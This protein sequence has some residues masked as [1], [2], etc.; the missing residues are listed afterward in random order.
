M[1]K[2][3]KEIIERL[4]GQNI[5]FAENLPDIEKQFA[6]CIN[7]GY[8]QFNE[9]LLYL[10]Y[11]RISKVFFQF[12][13]DGTLDYRSSST[14]SDFDKF[15]AH[16]EKII[17]YF[18]IL[19]GNVKFGYKQF[20]SESN[21]DEF[22][23]WYENLTPLHES[24]FKERHSPLFNLTI[25]DDDNTYYLGYLIQ[26]EIEQKL[27]E[28]P[29]NEQY[30]A[31]KAKMENIKDAGIKNHMAYLASDHMDVYVAT[32][33]RQK[34]EYLFI[35]RVTKEIFSHSALK[36]L[37]VRYFDPTQAY[38]SDRIDKGISEALMLKRAKCTIYLAQ[39]SD[40]L[41]KDS[42]LASTLAQGKTVIAYIPDGNE[43]FVNKL[44]QD[45][46]KLDPSKSRKE[47]ILEQLKAFNAE[48]CWKDKELRA[49]IDSETQ[50][51]A[52]A[53]NLLYTT[54][55]NKYDSRATT[56]KDTHPLGI[57]VNLES[58]VAN[59]VIVARTIDQCASL[60]RQVLLKDLKFKLSEETKNEITYILL[61]EVTTDSVYRVATGDKLLTNIFW[62][63]Y[64]PNK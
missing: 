11:D 42:E 10:G 3:F 18:L 7:L 14:I 38:C 4:T 24:D 28:D 53:L 46:Q 47:I 41:G 23:N 26:K 22:S 57:Q 35:S 34:H 45:L 12:L 32:S 36:E 16:A 17:E 40:T 37:N 9:V 25:I 54:V 64:L 13:V 31:M 61:K 49:W 55:S 30:L 48:L 43:E 8:S 56:L 52:Y 58:G 20:S 63:Y 29:N 59:G 50:D 39:E 62:N 2:S 1:S 44:L 5:P 60:V 27:K 33:M 21:E 19:F 15:K 51:E 6:T